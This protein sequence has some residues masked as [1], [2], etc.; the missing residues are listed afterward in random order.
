MPWTVWAI[1]LSICG[2]LLSIC[3]SALLL[4]DIRL[5]GG[6]SR[7]LGER[8]SGQ[9]EWKTDT[10]KLA[11][12]VPTHD[13]DVDRAFLNMKNWPSTCSS[14]TLS[15]VDLILYHATTADATMLR[16]GIP[17][18]ATACF[19]DTKVVCANLTPEVRSEI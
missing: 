2:Y 17:E 5:P 4:T 6:R 11:V 16:D 12:I 18:E 7:S 3:F 14:I 19:R 15:H 10:R 13:G 8:G 9:H 1:T